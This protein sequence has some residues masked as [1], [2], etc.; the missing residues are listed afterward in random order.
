MIITI[1][2][3][4]K[5]DKEQQ[6]EAEKLLSKKFA[7]PTFTYKVNKDLLGGLRVT[8]GSKR[9]DLSLAGKL[10]QVSATL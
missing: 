10:A 6:M 4:I 3:A 8:M 5:L 7:D 2:S 1:E 9:I